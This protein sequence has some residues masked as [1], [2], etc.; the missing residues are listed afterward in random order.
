MTNQC[1]GHHRSRALRPISASSL[2][3]ATVSLSLKFFL[4]EDFAHKRITRLSRN[5]IFDI[6]INNR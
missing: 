5:C 6:D 1:R 2:V 3:E 4:D